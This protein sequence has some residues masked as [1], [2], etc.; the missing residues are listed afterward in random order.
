MRV[1]R[2]NDVV[3]R[4]NRVH[5]GRGAAR[6]SDVQHVSLYFSSTRTS[7]SSRS[8]CIADDMPLDRA[9]DTL[10]RFGRA[11]P[12]YWERNGQGGNCPYLGGMA[13]A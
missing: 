6:C 9:Q 5:A 10:F 3:E 4:A 1:F 11:Y 13:R 8:R 2:R 7:R 12:A